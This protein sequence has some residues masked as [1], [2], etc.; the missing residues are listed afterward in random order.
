MS[1]HLRCSS[2]PLAFECPASTVPPAHRVEHPDRDAANLGS[3]A[4]FVPVET[5]TEQAA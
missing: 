5:A 2:L 3:A 1:L 4:H